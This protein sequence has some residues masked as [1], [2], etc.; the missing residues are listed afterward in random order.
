MEYGYVAKISNKN[1]YREV[2]L[3]VDAKYTKIGMDLDCDV[4]FYKESFFESFSLT[5]RKI[6]GV[7][8]ATCSDN[9]YLDV[10]DVRKLITKPLAHGDSFSVK[11]QNSESELFRIEFL[12]DFDNESKKYDRSIDVS[13]VNSFTIGSSS[14][15]NIVLR[16]SNINKDLIELTRTRQGL[17]LR[18]KSVAY[19]VYLNGKKASSGEIIRDTD[20]FSI[21]EFSFYYHNNVLKTSK[22]VLVNALTYN[23]EIDMGEY[24]KF[25]RNA[26]IHRSINEQ[27]IEIL[28]PSTK[29]EKPKTNLVMSMLPSMGMMLTSGA[30]MM[31]SAQGNGSWTMILF[32]GVSAGMA[33]I[34]AIAGFIDN[35]KNYK[36]SI[37]KRIDDYNDY[38]TRKKEEILKARVSEKDQMESL[39]FS[40]EKELDMLYRFSPELFDRQSTDWDY[41]FV[42][43]GSGPVLSKRGVEHK[44]QE[45]LELEDEIQMIPEQVK[46]EFTMLEDAPLVCD[47]KSANAVCICGDEPCRF[48]LFKN[49]VFD[50]CT[51]QF[52]SDVSLIF[53]CEEKNK[54]KINWLR[55]LPHVRND[56]TNGRNIVCDD[57]SKTRLFDYLYKELSQREELC[58]NNNDM[59]FSNHIVMFLYNEYGF[60]RHPISRFVR[61]GSKLGVTFVFMTESKDTAPENCS[62]IIDVTSS[63]RGELINT[64]NQ[65]SVC[66]F[67]YQPISDTVAKDTVRLLAPIYTEEVS[68]ES[69]L[70][71]S[72]TL[73]EMMKILMVE[74]IDLRENWKNSQVFKS[75]AAPIGVTKSDYV[76]LDLHDKAHGP[77]GLVAGTTG[78]GKSE[79]LQT[80][81]LSIATLFH[82]Y[83]VSFVIID[84]KG[85]GMVNQF[86]DLPHLLGAITNIDGKEIDRSLKSIKAELQKRQRL[87]AEAEVNHI[88]KYIKKYKAGEAKTPIPHLILIVDEFAELKAE[89][90]DFMKELIS[91]ARIG[92]SLGVHLILATQ[93]PSGQVDEQ[94][95][96]NSR[97]KLCLKVQGVEDS[98]E[99]L[100]S[101]LAAEIKEPG[102][103]YLQVGNNEIFELF[104]SAYSGAP[105]KMAETNVKEFAVYEV[106][107]SG[108]KTEVFKQK[109]KKNAEGNR[110]QLEAIVEHVHNYCE[111]EDI[112][113]LPNI[114]LPSLPEIISQPKATAPVRGMIDIGLYDDPD[115][116]V[117]DSTYIDITNK[118]TLII[119][120]SQYGKT[121]LLQS[122]I[123]SVT[124]NSSPAESVFYILDFGSMVLK[125]FES[126]NHV[127]GVVTSSDDEKLKNLFKL[128]FEEIN[129]RKEKLLTVG[130]SSFAS[131]LEAGYTDLPHIY[132]M[133]DNFTALSELYLENDDSL[134]TLIREGISFG[135]ST[136]I[137]NSQTAGIG[138]KYLSNFANKIVLYCND[139]N[140][141]TN[142][143]DHV[144]VKPDEKPG[145]CI[146]ELDKRL[147]EC[148]TYLAFEGEKEIDRVNQMRGFIGQINR[149]YPDQHARQIPCIPNVLTRESLAKEFD[150]Y[151]N[152]YSVPIGLTYEGVKPFFLNLEQ[153]GIIG[154]TGREN[155]GHK[156]LVT[157]LL[158]TLLGNPYHS[159][160]I[161][162]FDDISRKYAE[163]KNE[164]D[165]YSLNTEI[166][167]DIIRE[168]H[169]ELDRRY[170]KML[171]ED[172]M[173]DDNELLVMI[174][175]NNDVA[176]KIQSDFA[177]LDLFNE[178]MTRYVNMGVCIIFANYP[179]SP[180]SYDAPDP[181]RMVRQN[182]HVICL[183]DLQNMK[184]FDPPYEAIRDNKKPVSLGDG[185]YINNND[186][187]KLKIVSAEE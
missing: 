134:L 142:I 120:A 91:A 68:L 154:I 160:N 96:S 140:E 165:A 7:W 2:Q 93:K 75:M 50:I 61:L 149:K 65:N 183:E 145:R 162:I 45:K 119:G 44:K 5:L 107:D 74:D 124:E 16:S 114:C 58:K 88:D 98:N 80:Y 110:T 30:M 14:T 86:K 186:V 23:D 55:F 8:R 10:G 38:I 147:I 158:N 185:Y 157:Y 94:I 59:T 144:T 130:V 22:A 176:A 163:Y 136:I 37:Q 125:N 106:S 32:S 21:A 51:R 103:A 70:T 31:M 54:E 41:L 138:Y 12:F 171:L 53:V 101:P 60:Q 152:R 89:Q 166:V 104:Q 172:K 76:L 81:I 113:R 133:V 35:K 117:Q 90:P 25:T 57:E 20:F 95:W 128:L 135:I 178:M 19:G 105:E 139:S 129:A 184:C 170:N 26:R 34:T 179:N 112:H 151:T 79:L 177:V 83:E 82:P 173:D 137:A 100:K 168:W 148:Q 33:V 159:A 18:I 78:S 175:Q 143:Y 102:R 121:N 85:G 132:L 181:I 64:A 6:D 180:V 146:L 187:V 118:N 36:K 71:K 3:P 66:E 122:V 150:A 155:F 87:F 174:I 84:F 97:F 156:N 77:H 153:L 39:F 52:Y 141:Y 9:I 169:K 109:R 127:G 111:K 115:N 1:L 116:Q 11:Y 108:K 69:S 4:R 167:L 15:C 67:H 182:Q 43:L 62:W 164:V 126:L 28:D 161:V 40:T 46:Q 56:N 47:F 17:L 27:S 92:R 131:Y 13:T 123:K 24:P 73:F 72:I 42:R 99:V 48:D 29:P 63:E 49:I